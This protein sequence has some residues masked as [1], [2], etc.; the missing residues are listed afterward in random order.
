[1][2][3]R[4]LHIHCLSY[5]HTV[6]RPLHLSLDL[7][8]VCALPPFSLEAR[9]NKR[10]PDFEPCEVVTDAHS[11]LEKAQRVVMDWHAMPHMLD[12]HSTT[13][14]G[15]SIRPESTV[16]T[17]SHA[18]MKQTVNARSQRKR[19]QVENFVS[20]LVVAAPPA[21][22]IIVDFGSG[23]GYVRPTQNVFLFPSW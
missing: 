5:T 21:G 1:M 9:L 17:S 4:S 16:D 6:Y 3:A 22:S 18:A 7:M 8:C 23:S 10:Q 19:A 13:W 12:P 2:L 11:A 20:L 14:R 15:T